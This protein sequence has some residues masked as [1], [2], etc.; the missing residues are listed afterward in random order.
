V[1]SQ[2]PKMPKDNVSDG[3]DMNTKDVEG[4]VAAELPSLSGD[5]RGL[6]EASKTVPYPVA[7]TD[8]RGVESQ[9]WIVLRVSNRVVFWDSTE[10]EFGVGRLVDVAQVTEAELLG[11]L[12]W[13]I[14]KVATSLPQPRGSR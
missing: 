8:A 10:E 7:F 6:F 13:A 9:L 14:S 4:I 5:D 1:D 12:Q 11:S 3:S 2:C